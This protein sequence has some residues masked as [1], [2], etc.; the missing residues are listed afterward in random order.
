MKI[1]EDFTF[2]NINCVFESVL[3]SFLNYS[4]GNTSLRSVW[5]CGQYG[6]E[7]MTFEF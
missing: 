3:I 2:P 4:G 5:T 7:P 6:I 1:L